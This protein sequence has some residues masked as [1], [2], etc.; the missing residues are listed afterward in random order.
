MSDIPTL[1]G[2]F[3]PLLKGASFVAI[4]TGVAKGFE[5]VD[6]G[7]GQ[8]GRR[9]LSQWLTNVPGDEQIDAWAQVF[10]NLI[11]RVFGPKA[12]SWKFFFRSCIASFIAV[13]VVF[14]IFAT[15]YG[16][17]WLLE[18]TATGGTF[19]SLFTYFVT[20]LLVNCIPDYLSIVI[21]RFIVRSM[22]RRPPATHLRFH[23]VPT[24]SAP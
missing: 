11:D 23:F 13:V 16:F 8:A 5:W 20:A 3:A 12:L 22:S 24:G 18:Q 7:M 4:V 14:A 9:R 15:H 17:F 21:S 19:Q 10:P 6:G 2:Q 1:L